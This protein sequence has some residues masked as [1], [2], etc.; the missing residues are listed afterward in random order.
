MEAQTIRLLF[1]LIQSIVLGAAII[2]SAVALRSILTYIIYMY[3]DRSITMPAK[4]LVVPGSLWTLFYFL[5]KASSIMI[6]MALLK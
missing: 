3:L 2:Y 5:S 6:A 1:I 4:I